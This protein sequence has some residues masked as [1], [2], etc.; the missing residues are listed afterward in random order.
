MIYDEVKYWNSRKNPNSASEK[1]TKKHIS[2]IRKYIQDN[3]Y[4]LDFGPGVGRTFSAYENLNV[5]VEGYDISNK[6]AKQ[7]ML[8][9]KSLNMDFNLT[10]GNEIKDLPY[11]DNTF[12]CSVAISVL[13]HQ[14]P[15]H[16]ISVMKELVRVSKRVIVVS[17]YE[18]VRSFANL[19]KIVNSNEYCF[20]Y[21][22]PDICKSNKWH[23]I[24][25]HIEDKQIFFVYESRD[26]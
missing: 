3:K 20:N 22:Y 1:S 5:K 11:E 9:S 23:I 26:K 7:V 21:D 8:K 16:I 14:K 19:N 13:I 25:K 10:I 4:I 6:Y 24:H 15:N 17:W 12:D 18:P 2:F